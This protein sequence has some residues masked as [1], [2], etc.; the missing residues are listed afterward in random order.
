MV[1]LKQTNNN[2]ICSDGSGNQN[3]IDTELTFFNSI[4][5]NSI[6]N[7]ATALIKEAIGDC[8]PGYTCVIL[9]NCH[10]IVMQ[11]PMYECAL[12]NIHLEQ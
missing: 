5:P 12:C 4:I 2:L 1:E 10:D 7:E 3:C 9:S 6:T 11:A 8:V